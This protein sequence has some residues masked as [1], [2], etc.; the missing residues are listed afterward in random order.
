MY[1]TLKST[2]SYLNTEPNKTHMSHCDHSQFMKN[3][4]MGDIKSAQRWQPPEPAIRS[5][6]SFVTLKTSQGGAKKSDKVSMG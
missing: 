2:E 4:V 6:E 3:F 5:M 1:K